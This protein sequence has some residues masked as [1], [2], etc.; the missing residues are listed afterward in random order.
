MI[1]YTLLT[2]VGALFALPKWL[3]QK[4]YKG[5]IQQRLGLSLP[6]SS[7]KKPVIWTHMVSMGETRAMIPVIS[8]LQKKY[9]NAAYYFSS[10]TATGHQE[11]KKAFPEAESHFYLPLDHPWIIKRVVDQ[12]QPDLFLL[13]ETDFW[14]NLLNAV[15]KRGGKTLL[16]NGKISLPSA[17]RYA[18]LPSFS[19]KLFD[20][21]DHLC[22][23]N[24]AY[25]RHFAALGIPKEKITE[26]GNLKL[27]VPKENFD[28]S[29]LRKQFGLT[30]TDRVLTIGSTHEG[31]E[32]LLLQYIPSHYKILLAPRHPHRQSSLRNLPTHVTLIEEMGLLP[33]LYQLSEVA[34]VG[35]SFIRGVGG[36]NIYEPIQAGIP[37]IFGPHMENQTELA[38]VILNAKAGIQTKA[39]A[40]PQALERAPELLENVKKL[41]GNNLEIVKNTLAILESHLS[42]CH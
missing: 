12:I 6:P 15:K 17:Q 9:P 18:K 34:I 30:E 27:C 24:G 33:L 28:L 32:E 36:H 29:L 16:L 41:A 39:K 35:G 2:T 22:V 37:V 19:Q 14:Y 3:L 4:K 38:R 10:T 8:T 31:E 23:Q 1:A 40:L 13:S 11:A 21:I 20:K 7:T 25:A 42:P 5:S 26:T